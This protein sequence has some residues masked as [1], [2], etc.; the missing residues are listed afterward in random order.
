MSNIPSKIT[1]HRKPWEHFRL[2]EKRQTN[3]GW[4]HEDTDAEIVSDFKAMLTQM[5]QQATAN[6][7]GKMEKQKSQ[8]RNTR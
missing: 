8:Q 7:W 3:R 6:T 4:Y 1:R 2:Q 5:L